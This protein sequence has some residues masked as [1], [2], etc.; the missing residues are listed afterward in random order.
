MA[1]KMA[2]YLAMSFAILN[3]VKEPRVINNCLPIKTTSINL[4]GL[5]SKSIKFAASFALVVP[6]FIAKPTFASA[7]AGASLVP[8]PV[9][10][11]ICPFACSS[12]MTLILSSGLHS[13]IKRSTPASFAIVAAVSALSPVHITVSI[14]ITRNSWNRSTNPSL[15]TSF[16]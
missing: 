5:E 3:V 14:P 9:I 4:V 6:E 2:K 15:M 16:K 1:G 13:A 11:T 10:A 12:L 7:R 8:S